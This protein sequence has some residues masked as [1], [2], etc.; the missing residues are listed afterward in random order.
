[1]STSFLKSVFETPL[2]HWILTRTRFSNNP[3]GYLTVEVRIRK[4]IHRTLPQAAVGR[5]GFEV[6][7]ESRSQKSMTYRY[8]WKCPKN[9]SRSWNNATLKLDRA[10]VPHPTHFTI[11]ERKLENAPPGGRP[12]KRQ[13]VRFREGTWHA[14]CAPRQ[15]TKRHRTAATTHVDQSTAGN[16]FWG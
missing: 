15:D 6:P 4:L 16:Q 8:S 14:V 13:D 10:S 3:R 7:E 11:S 1:M 5:I 9:I 2:N 12:L